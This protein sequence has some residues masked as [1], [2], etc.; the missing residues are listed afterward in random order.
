MK[1]R[2]IPLLAV[3]AL[4]VVAGFVGAQTVHREQP[5]YNITA[6]AGDTTLHF[7]RLT[8]ATQVATRDAAQWITYYPT[9]NATGYT[10]EVPEAGSFTISTQI[11]SLTIHRDGTTALT[12]VWANK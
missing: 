5:S 1:M 8:V 3:L 4:I 11:D 10:L 12:V 6:T 9:L 2:T 7:S